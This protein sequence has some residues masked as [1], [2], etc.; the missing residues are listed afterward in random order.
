MSLMIERIFSWNG[1]QEILLIRD[2]WH[3]SKL[4]YFVVTLKK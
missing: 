2:S 1:V 3:F 4:F